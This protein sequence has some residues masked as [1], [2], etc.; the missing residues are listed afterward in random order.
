MRRL[1]Q[2]PAVTHGRWRGRLAALLLGV[3]LSLLLAETLARLFA[4][5]FRG[6]H[7]YPS[8][9]MRDNFMSQER[10]GQ[11]DEKLGWRLR[12]DAEV[13]NEVMEFSHAIRTN[14]AGFRDD[15]TSFERTGS[16]RRILLLG[17]SFCMGDGVE[18]EEGI[19]D[20]LERRLPDTE[21]INLAV[22]GYGTDQELLLYEMEGHRYEVD[23]V[24][25]GFLTSNDVI[26]NAT[27]Q[28][29][30]RRKP[31]FR[32]RGG[33]LALE[34]VP[35]PYRESGSEGRPAPP[36][37]AFPVHAWLDVHSACYAL[38]FQSLTRIEALRQ[39]WQASGLL[40]EQS[41]VFI[42]GHLPM[43]EKQSHPMIRR[44]WRVTEAILVRFRDRVREAG[45]IPVVFAIPSNI[46]VDAEAWRQA[47]SDLD[48]D[49][50]LYDIEQPNRRVLEICER[51]GIA[52][53][54]LLP[55][56]RS[57]S[58]AG[59][60]LYYRRNPHWTAEGHRVAAELLAD[61]LTRELGAD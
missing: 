31:A 3:A 18:R 26:N 36:A 61:F 28:Q 42:R 20:R 55:G 32:L 4:P 9:G 43:L 54:D 14:S 12:P 45:A 52:A 46:Q 44:G 53:F 34:G 8:G 39:R 11:Y 56:L 59:A 16:R 1:S 40:P 24:L 30:G 37:P 58:E 23:V 38:G 48:L 47:V 49:P 17:D 10:L 2:N 25:L 51:H 5:D 6:F 50:G 19:A 15:E 41:D 13:R 57:A 33:E 29:Y 60:A 7:V 22:N 27:L 35:V 21:V